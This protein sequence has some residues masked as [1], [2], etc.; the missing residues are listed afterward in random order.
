MADKEN[1]IVELKP[2]QM[3]VDSKTL[4]NVLEKQAEM[5]KKFE[6]ERAKNA[7]LAEM[8]A[9]MKEDGGGKLREKKSFAPAFRTVRMRKYKVGGDH[10]NEAVVIGWTKR[11]SY[12]IVDRSGVTPTTVDMI[13][14]LF[15]GPDGKPMR[16]KDDPNKLYAESVPLLSVMNAPQIVC[17]ILEVKDYEGKQYTFRY[18]PL[19]EDQ[20]IL[21]RPGEEKVKTGEEIDVTMWD[22]QHG[23]VATG[24]KIDGWVAYTNLTFVIQIPGY[25]EPVEIDQQFVNL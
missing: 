25:P 23:L 8:I 20:A 22:P 5:E 11:G 14:V 7:G 10:N 4:S 12:Q 2:G 16:S 24:E 3:V 18:L 9:S 6:D 19:H 15:L 21:A 1:D 17:K 13:D